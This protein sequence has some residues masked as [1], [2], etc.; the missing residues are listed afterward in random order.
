MAAPKDGGAYLRSLPPPI[1]EIA[2]ALRD[3][4]RS[5]APELE[6]KIKYRAPHYDVRGTAGT[7]V[8]I[9]DA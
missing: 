7:V 8:Y 3:L 1:R 2:A 4:V 5:A 9:A 6:E